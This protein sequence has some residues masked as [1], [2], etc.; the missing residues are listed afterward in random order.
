MLVAM[1]RTKRLESVLREEDHA[2]D[3]FRDAVVIGT[4]HFYTFGGFVHILL[5]LAVIVLAIRLVQGRRV[6]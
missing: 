4:G 2:L 5:V 1:K 3:N 6:A